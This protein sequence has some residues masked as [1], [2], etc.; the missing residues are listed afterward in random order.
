MIDSPL[1]HPTAIIDTGAVIAEDAVIDAYCIIGP[2]VTIGSR[3]RLHPH[4]QLIEN[5]K[6]G[7]ECEI[8]GGTQIGGPP[9]DTKFK[10]EVSFVVIGDQNI[11]REYSTI[12]RA[13][14]EGKITRIGDNN[15]LMAYAHV[16]HNC[17][18]GSHVSIA[19][20]VGVSGHVLI[21]DNVNIGGMTGIHQ[22]GRIGTLA[23]IGGLSGLNRDVPPYMIAEG[24]PARVY[25]INIRG[26]RRAGIPPKVRAELRQAY[27]LLYRTNLNVSQALEAIEDEIEKSPELDLLLHFVR[28]TREGIG[29][30]GNSPQIESS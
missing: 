13:T 24:R 10:N 29:G 28:T 14:G 23:M 6:I 19:S 20:Y 8:F 26:L 30:R 11:I 22:H 18:I 3:T 27:K 4:V 16:G 5:S 21:G 1:I 7:R 25:D 2:G 9:Q 17:E 15:M 12:H